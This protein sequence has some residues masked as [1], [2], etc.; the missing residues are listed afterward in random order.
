MLFASK[1]AVVTIEPIAWLTKEIAAD[2]ISV[3]TMVQ[4]G[5]SAHTYEP[6]PAQM[7]ALSKA[8]YYFAIGVEFEDIWLKKFARLNKNLQIIKTDEGIKKLSSSHRHGDHYHSKDDTHIWLSPKNMTIIAQN[9]AKTL[10][11]TDKENAHIYRQNL[12]TLMSKLQKLDNEV[13]A[14]LAPYKNR[15]FL[16]FHP[17]WGY[18]AN[19]YNLEQ[20]AVEKEGKEPKPKELQ[21]TIKIAQNHKI[22]AIFAHSTQSTKS[23]EV[24]AKS[25]NARVLL[26]DPLAYE[27]DQMIRHTAK[28]LQ[29]TFVE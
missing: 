22:K 14:L 4:K 25:I 6:K 15:A 28:E 10:I 11:E 18:F 16:V 26:L 7:Q 19:E 5:A 9:I 23:A 3:T 13:R 12:E 29:R 24:I 17:A 21:D 8:D 1:S 2:Q 20:I 27:Y